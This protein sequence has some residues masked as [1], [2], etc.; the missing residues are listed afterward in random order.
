LGSGR[1]KAFP[2][3]VGIDINHEFGKLSH[4]LR[5]E[6]SIDCQDLSIFSS[7]SMDFV[8]S[9]HL[10]GHLEDYRAVLKEWWRVVKP[11]GHLCL[12]LPHKDLHPN[13]GR[14]GAN[15]HHKHDLL[16][17]DIEQAMLKIGSW[18]LVEDQV[19]DDEDE[20]S[21]FQVYKRLTG[22]RH[23]YTAREPKPSKTCAVV[24][25]GAFGDA[26]Q[27]SSIFPG[28]KQQG[29]HLT[30]FCVPGAHQVLKED[31]HIDRF[32][33]QADNQVPNAWLG[34]FWQVM[35]KKY[36]RFINLSESIEGTL[37]A[38]PGRVNHLWP[39]AVRHRYMNR[40]YLEW[41]HELAQVPYEGKGVSFYATDL[42]RAWAKKERSKMGP[43]VVLWSLSGSAVHK[44]WPYLD[45]IVARLMLDT[46]A[47][48][49]MVGGDDG[50]ML[51]SGWENEPRV[52][53]TSGKWS[54]R[55]SMAFCEVADLIIGTETGLMSAA[56]FLPAPKIITL[57]H[58]STENL[59]RDWT[60]TTALVSANTP[61]YPC[62]LLH[63][64]FQ[65]CPR[66]LDPECEACKTKTCGVHTGTS[67]CSADISSAQM[68]DA[69]AQVL[70]D[71][72]RMR[73]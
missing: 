53:R 59:T 13:I 51:E 66:D 64:G 5:P 73:A 29:F 8:F 37:L 26:I 42:E 34:E 60:N 6:M 39:Q 35:G 33:V 24:R 2:H 30:L 70:T 45:A 1:T 20:Y 31:P 18:D 69:I 28:L 23:R 44:A 16:P 61:C 54:I 36:D 32:I 68:W 67:K 25:Y 21:F 9:S 46:D 55:E 7:E 48:V 52:H 22:T 14:P 19:R 15:E 58:S 71:K 57:S 43:F 27:A 38:L 40:N 72:E 4:A 50:V 62:H 65:Y 11:G 17:S 12:Y 56:A 41:T 49:V 3:F 10:L 47:H 63:Y